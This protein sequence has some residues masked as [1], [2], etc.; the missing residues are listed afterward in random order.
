[1]SEVLQNAP[2]G[3]FHNTFDLLKVKIGLENQFW[4]FNKWPFSGPVTLYHFRQLIYK[5]RRMKNIS[6]LIDDLH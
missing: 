5:C 6:S 4:S 3:V 1:M 2:L